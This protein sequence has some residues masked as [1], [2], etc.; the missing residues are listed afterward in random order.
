[1]ALHPHRKLGL[2]L[3]A[4]G[5]VEPLETPDD[6]AIREAL[7]ETGLTI[8]LDDHGWPAPPEQSPL[9]AAGPVPLARPLGVQ[10]ATVAPQHEHI[11]LVYAA[12]PADGAVL[13]SLA[14]EFRWL[15]ASEAREIGAPPDVVTWAALVTGA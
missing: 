2:W 7:E 6:A 15:T 3:P 9:Q 12:R 11:D 8:V 1:M 13:P 14:E 4:G 5:H 10:L